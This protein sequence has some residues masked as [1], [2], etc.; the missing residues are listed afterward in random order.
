MHVY[1]ELV[2]CLISPT[3]KVNNSISLEGFFLTKHELIQVKN[4]A[5]AMVFSF[6][7]FKNK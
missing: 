2:E 7:F 4:D 6:L 3:F 1:L 5:L